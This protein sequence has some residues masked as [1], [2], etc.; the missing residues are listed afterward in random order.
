MD[1][2]RKY[3]ERDGENDDLA[4]KSNYRER[5]TEEDYDPGYEAGGD[6]Y[7]E[8]ELGTDYEDLEDR[9]YEVEADYRERYPNLTDEDV[10]VE[11]GRFDRTLERIGRRTD[12]S[13]HQ[14]RQDIE[15]WH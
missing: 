10:N 5:N 11:A 6:D 9:W 3:M 13:P 8:D 12:R 15:N 7:S 1:R 2:N 14:V 4:E